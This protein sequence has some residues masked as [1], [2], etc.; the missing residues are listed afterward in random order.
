[1]PRCSAPWASWICC[2]GPLINFRKLVTLIT[3]Y[4]SPEPSLFLFICIYF[5]AFDLVSQFLDYLFLQSSLLNFCSPIV[6]VLRNSQWYF[7]FLSQWFL[8][9]GMSFP[10]SSHPCFFLYWPSVLTRFLIFSIKFL[11]VLIITILKIQLD[12]MPYWIRIN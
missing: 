4:I 9:S 6:Y 1:M 3:L 5:C 2:L 10:S 7:S 12:D 8:T 11:D